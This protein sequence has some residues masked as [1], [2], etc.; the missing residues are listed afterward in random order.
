MDDIALSIVV[1]TYNHENYIVKAL[2]SILMQ[3]TRYTYEVLVGEDVS[4]D[5]TREVLKEYEKKHPGKLTVF[6]RE[7]N[8]RTEKH[9]NFTDLRLRSKGKYIIALEGD[10][11]WTSDQKIEKEINFLE[12]HPEYIAVSHNCVIV[13]ENDNETGET[14]PECKDEEYTMKHFLNGIYPGQTT[15]VMY[16]NF[17]KEYIFDKSIL[18]KHL[19]PGDKLLYFALVTSGKIF[20]MQEVMSAY[21]YVKKSGSSYSAN[22]KYDFLKDV[23]WYTELLKYA[24]K[25]NDKYALKCVGALYIGCLIHGLKARQL[26]FGDFLGYLSK[27]KTKTSSFFLYFLRMYNIHIRHIGSA[28]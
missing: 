7:K 5:N 26:K 12:A 22:Y 15:T 1:P 23:H 11:Y 10:D 4:T 19:I 28:N 27:V 20:C 9:G 14:Y 16:K 2:D 13:D 17:V 8:M 24:G 6:Y 3:K 21:R 25:V 18:E